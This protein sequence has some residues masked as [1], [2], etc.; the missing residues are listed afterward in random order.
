MKTIRIILRMST[1]SSLKFTLSGFDLKFYLFIF[2]LPLNV[3]Y[4]LVYNPSD[5]IVSVFVSVF[6]G[7]LSRFL[8][9]PSLC[10]SK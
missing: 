3:I 6:C 10:F 8:S 7:T 1:G 2:H 4:F 9:L 5:G